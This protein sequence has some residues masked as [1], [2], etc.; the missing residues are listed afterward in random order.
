M[1]EPRPAGL[2]VKTEE[3]GARVEARTWGWRHG[4]RHAWALNSIDLDIVPGERILILGPSGSGKST[5]LAGLAGILGGEDEGEAR[6]SL[7]VDGMPPEQQ[8]GRIGLVMQD[9]E[10]QVVL[11]RVGDD[12]AFPMENLSVP[13][14][15]IWPRVG[16]ALQEVGLGLPFDHPTSALSGGQKQRLALAAILAMRPGLLILDEPTANLDPVGV[17]EVRDAVE[18]VL[19][20]SGATLVVVEHRVDVWAGLVDRIIVILEG[21][22]AAD[23]PVERILAEQGN[24]LKEQG[25]WLPGDDVAAAV[26]TLEKRRPETSPSDPI[27][28]V[29]GL[30]IGYDPEHPIRTGIDLDIARGQSTCI[31]GPNGTGKSTLGLTLAGLLP[32]LD[33]NV[34]AAPRNPV[35]SASADPHQWRSADLLGRISM[36]FQE[37]EYQFLA[38]SVREELEIGP[39][40][41][42]MS[43][44]ELVPL[45]EEHLKA[46]GLSTLAEANPMTLSGGEK[47]RLSVA[48]ALISAPELLILDEPTFGQDRGTWIGLVRLLREARDR[49]TTLVSI[50]HDPAYVAAMGDTVIDLSDIGAPGRAGRTGTAGSAGNSGSAGASRG[51]GNSRSTENLGGTEGAK[52]DSRGARENGG[53]NRTNLPGEN[54]TRS[55]NEGLCGASTPRQ[56]AT[57]NDTLSLS[58]GAARNDTPA[59]SENAARTGN[60]PSNENE[61]ASCAQVHSAAERKA[62]ST[63]LDVPSRRLRLLNRV[64]PVTQVLAL[65]VMT[66]PLLITI[67]PIS[68]GTALGLEILLLPLAQIRPTTLALRMI[69]LLIAAPI[70]ALSMLLYAN[71]GGEIFWSLGPAIISERSIRLALGILVRVLAVGAPA[72]ILLSKIDPTDMAD[73]LSQ[74][75]HMPARPVLAT[76]AAARMTGLMAADWKALE[77]ARRIRGIGDA[78]VVVSALRGSFSLLVFALRRS[79]KLSLTMEARGFGTARTRTWARPSHVGMAD[80]VMMI[81]ALIIP[82]AALTA[83]V[84][85]GSFELIGR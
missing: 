17:A 69:P 77:Q 43:E 29:R 75:L 1:S 22:I 78:R 40:Q 48:S 61:S 80:A 32:A 66:T 67:D 42:G 23:G 57:Q 6:G 13:R 59:L 73:G 82:A 4:G 47:R 81:V 16:Q 34:S 79:A 62:L 12:V 19:A 20:A 24:L 72:I 39:R 71:P 58:E 21:R 31:V 70:A 50:T 7:S 27:L 41:A 60:G 56:S 8:R 14:E 53:V 11:A 2:L 68:A 9:P 65:I 51:T 55:E 38:R 46:L 15:Q 74:V 33:G 76:L 64:N 49:G 5:L 84:L 3:A 36:V 30:T 26:G 83:S 25:I 37:P 35:R 52:N 18:G 54:R 28:S 63:R 44:D 10:A 85:S 45:V